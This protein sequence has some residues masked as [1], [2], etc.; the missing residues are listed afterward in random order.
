LE[1]IEKYLFHTPFIKQTW[2]SSSTFSRNV[3]CGENIKYILKYIYIFYFLCCGV[4]TFPSLLKV[5]LW[6]ST[7]MEHFCP[8]DVCTLCWIFVKHFVNC[9]LNQI[10]CDLFILFN[11]FWTDKSTKEIFPMFCTDQLL[12]YFDGCNTFQKS[13]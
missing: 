9:Y 1:K 10:I 7:L 3:S 8:L 2:S 12:F 11:I 6:L 13:C 5:F 4:Q